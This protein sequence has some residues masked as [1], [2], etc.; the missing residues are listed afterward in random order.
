MFNL[1]KDAIQSLNLDLNNI[2]GEYFDG[3]SSMSGIHGGLATLLKETSPLQIY[4]HC[5]A[6]RLN[7]ALEGSLSLGSNLK[8]ALDTIQSL[9]NFID[10]SAKRASFNNIEG[11]LLSLSLK[12]LSETRWVSRHEAI[13][14]VYKQLERIIKTLAFLVLDKYSDVRTS[15]EARCLLEKICTPNFCFS[16]CVLKFILSNTRA[17]CTCFQGKFVDVFHAQKNQT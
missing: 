2:V 12:L 13:R 4:V 16:L 5:Y 14:A 1:A 9:Y 10:G 11:E 8:N 15:S 17:L 6:H 3:V 7:L